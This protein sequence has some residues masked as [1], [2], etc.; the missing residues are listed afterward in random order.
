M[1]RFLLLKPSISPTNSP[2]KTLIDTQSSIESRIDFIDQKL[3]Q[4]EKDIRDLLKQNLS[5]N[6][7]QTKALV[8]LKRKKMLEEQKHQL[9]EILLTVD[10]ASTQQILLNTTLQTAEALQTDAKI[11]REQMQNLNLDDIQTLHFDLEEANSH[12]KD[13]F[14]A[15]C[16]DNIVTNNEDLEKEFQQLF[17]KHV[18]TPPNQHVKQKSQF[19]SYYPTE[20]LPPIPNTS[21]SSM[22]KK[23]GFFTK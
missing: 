6:V 15:L 1:K 13:A 2:Q 20:T 7:L 3:S 4:C 9:Y 19:P 16:F 21:L 11:M 8:F 18:N 10:R 17:Q 12:Q 5:N 23:T 22:M 14:D